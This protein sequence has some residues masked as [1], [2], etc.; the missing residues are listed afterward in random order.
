VALARNNAAE[1]SNSI[2]RNFSPAAPSFLTV[3]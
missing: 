3:F 1:P 2:I